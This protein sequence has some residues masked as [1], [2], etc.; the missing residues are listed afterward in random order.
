MDFSA[1]LRFLINEYDAKQR[2]LYTPTDL[3]VEYWQEERRSSNEPLPEQELL[4]HLKTEQKREQQAE[5]L[6]VLA[7]LRRYVQRGHV[8]LVGKPGLGKSVALQQIRWELAEAALVDEQQPIPILVAL[9]KDYSIIEAIK[10]EL[11]KGKVELEE[12]EIKQLLRRQHFFLLLDGLNE[13]RSKQQLYELRQ[14]HKDNPHTPIIFTSRGFG[15]ELEIEQKLEMGKLTEQQI[16]SFVEKHLPDYSEVLL[17]QLKD[18][19]REL[20]ET[21]LI[22]KLLCEIF[23]LKTQNFPQSQGKLLRALDAQFNNWKQGEGVRSTEK[24]WQ[25]NGELLRGLA[26]EMLQADGTPTKKWLKIERDQAELLL[27]KFLQGRVAAPGEKAK[28]WLQDLLDHHLLQVAT[29]PN[30]IEFHHQLFQEYYA[31]EYLLRQLTKLSDVKLKRDYLNLL[32]WTEPLAVMLSVVS[33]KEAVLIV[34][35]AQQVDWMLGIRLAGEVKPEFQTQTLGMVNGLDLPEWLRVKLWKRKQPDV[36]RIATS[37]SEK[38]YAEVDIPDLLKV[39]EHKNSSVRAAAVRNLGSIKTETTTQVLLQVLANHEENDS[40]REVAALTLG[41]MSA[42]VAIPTLLT[43]A[44]ISHHNSS[45]RRSIVSALGEIG[46]ESSIS[47]LC[48][49]IAHD[50]ACYDDICMDAQVPD[51]ARSTLGAIRTETAI[52]GLLKALEHSIFEVRSTAAF[53]LGK[54]GSEAAI[55]AL[56]K[57]WA[58][59]DF[60]VRKVAVTAVGQIASEAAIP[61]LLEA[62][63]HEKAIVR[64]A[65]VVALGNIRSKIAIPVLLQTIEG[66]DESSVRE[67]AVEALGKIATANDDNSSVREAAVAALGKNATEAAIPILIQTLANDDNSSVHKAAVVALRRIA[68]EAAIPDLLQAMEHK[69]VIVRMAAAA[70][71]GQIASKAA[72]PVLLQTIE[73]NDESSVCQAAVS[74]LGYIGSEM[75][76]STLIQVLAND[77]KSSIWAAT[78][79]SLGYIGSEMAVST[80]IQVLANDDK[81]SIWAATVRSLGAIGSEAAIPALIQVL[82]NNSKHSTICEV[83]VEAL[84]AIGSEAAV[85]TLIQMMEDNDIFRGSSL[86]KASVLAL[87]KIGSEAAIHALSHALVD[88]RNSGRWRT[89]V[90]ENVVEVLRDI[91]TETTIPALLQALTDEASGVRS[92]AVIALGNINSVAAIP[93]L[94]QALEDSNKYL[95]EKVAEALENI[96]TNH[97]EAIA[98]QI[99]NLTNLVLTDFVEEAFQVLISIQAKCQ[100]YNWTIQNEN[101]IPQNEKDS[102]RISEEW[103]QTLTGEIQKMS[104]QS[105]NHFN[106]VNFNAP[107]NFGDSPA[108]DFIGTQNNYATNPE[109]QRTINDLK[110]L[111]SN[112]QAQYPTLTNEAHAL[113]IIDAEF[114]E[115]RQDGT[116][117]F[118]ALR[119][120]LLN[121]ERHLQAT[122]ATLAEVGKHY[123]EESVWAKAAIT[124][125]D[126]LSEE[127]N[128]GV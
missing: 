11:L 52:P 75:A 86:Y 64:I 2:D 8:L 31:A 38:I 85:P 78:V 58:G 21:P 25:W 18:Y 123:L 98:L 68:T 51:Y 87:G 124:Y 79:S 104:S 121:P 81:S 15:T 41:K 109:I 6:E 32:K 60:M 106:G 73:D 23:D 28:D 94:I 29:N 49:V 43:E 111:I 83:A 63:K 14:F 55:P 9:W 74:S 59:D 82:A 95:R 40:V 99:P 57:A 35:L 5:C 26:F 62:M 45:L 70:A 56:I 80:L 110:I 71:L 115:I 89:D 39:M 54:I 88:E 20:A 101:S 117:K 65:A 72:I 50:D 33:E 114:T 19:L 30:E 128:H 102:H 17:R 46:I 122:K 36:Y 103:L 53:V 7:G 107:V 120:Q 118:A 125:L 3:R 113:A 76:V 48:E 61:D 42:E 97:L 4:N 37:G 100:F 90:R 27:E 91:G 16:Q 116:N 69:K 67:A 105:Q 47:A 84:G 22:L 12:K 13:I 93:A 92:E 119:K 10:I 126:K 66:N 1:Y 96:S 127:P 112:L 34:E 108:G 77:D 44:L 24:F